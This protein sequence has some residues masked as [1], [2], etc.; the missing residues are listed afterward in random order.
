MS[1]LKY[2]STLHFYIISPDCVV[3]NI[4]PI[5]Y[6]HN[7]GSVVRYARFGVMLYNHIAHLWCIYLLKLPPRRILYKI[8]AVGTSVKLV[9]EGCCSVDAGLKF[10]ARKRSYRFAQ[11]TKHS[12]QRENSYLEQLRLLQV[13][14][15]SRC[16]RSCDN[17]YRSQ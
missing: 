14:D 4:F 6:I 12:L 11:P 1:N 7:Y 5:S 3:D 17:R 13:A 8:L 15:N 9:E 2:F 10:L 16:R